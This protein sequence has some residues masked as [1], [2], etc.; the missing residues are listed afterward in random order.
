MSLQPLDGKLVADQ[1]THDYVVMHQHYDKD[2]IVR[3]TLHQCPVV[4]GHT[5]RNDLV[6]MYAG[7]FLTDKRSPAVQEHILY[8]AGTRNR[9]QDIFLCS[10]IKS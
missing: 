5:V 9:G 2:D 1:C 6:N 8:T 10:L 4:T 3:R 7:R